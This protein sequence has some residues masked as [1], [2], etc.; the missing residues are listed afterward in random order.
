MPDLNHHPV[1]LVMTI[2]VITPLLAEIPIGFLV[3]F[4]FV[5]SGVNFDLGALLQCAQSMLLVPAFLALFV[6][7]RGTP[8]FLYPN[9]LATGERLPFALYA[10]T[11]LLMVVAITHIGVQTG[12]MPTDLAATLVGAGMVSVLVF[13]ALGNALRSGKPNFHAA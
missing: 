12:R 5:T 13:P 8:V 1:F 4:F 6:A 7:V 9:D 11:A 10:S 3:P 2:A